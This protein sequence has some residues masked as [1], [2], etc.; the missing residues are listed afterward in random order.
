[1]DVCTEHKYGKL[2]AVGVI[3]TS[4]Q[5][6]NVSEVARARIM[7]ECRATSAAE[8]RAKDSATVVVMV[9]MM[10]VVVAETAINDKTRFSSKA[11]HPPAMART[12][13]VHFQASLCVVVK[14]ALAA[15]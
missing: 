15:Q 7:C 8:A 5:L 1:M 11:S 13:I 9:V 3:A 14:S 4:C 6:A 2:V 10:M 12:T